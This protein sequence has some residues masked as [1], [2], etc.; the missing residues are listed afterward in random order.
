MFSKVD[1]RGQK[2]FNQDIKLV[3]TLKEL[4][5]TLPP[6]ELPLINDYLLIETYGCSLGWGAILLAKTPH[7][8]S[9]KNIKKNCRYN[10]GKHKENSNI[11]NIDT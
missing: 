1:S 5:T 4:V 10:S 11:S 7:K 2:Y 9:A 6:L 3:K 8:Y